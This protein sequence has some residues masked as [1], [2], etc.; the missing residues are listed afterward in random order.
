MADVE[1]Q[2]N[3]LAL[4]PKVVDWNMPLYFYDYLRSGSMTSARGW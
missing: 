4:K 1:F 3:A 2:D